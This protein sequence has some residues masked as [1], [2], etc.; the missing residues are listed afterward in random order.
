MTAAAIRGAAAATI[1]L[2]AVAASAPAAA[3][4][5]HLLL[6]LC[7]HSHAAALHGFL[8]NQQLP[9]ACVRAL[10][11]SSSG[12]AAADPSQ[13]RARVLDGKAVAA[14]IA[15]ELQPQVADLSRALNRR[16]GLAVVLVGARPDSLVYVTRKQEAC[17]CVC[18]WVGARCHAL[19]PCPPTN[20]HS[21]TGAP[22]PRTALRCLPP[23][24]CHTHLS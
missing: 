19:Q 12:A 5:S 17:R 13:R 22:S 10:S 3:A 20:V 8:L 4:A 1:G 21:R 23:R 24:T 2:R 15:A 18:V 9:W 11:T 7:G 16:P 6:S 14:A